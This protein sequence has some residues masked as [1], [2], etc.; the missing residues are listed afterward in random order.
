MLRKW[1]N[2]KQDGWTSSRN[3]NETSY[4]GSTHFLV[5]ENRKQK[6]EKEK[7]KEGW[8]NI[9]RTVS[10]IETIAIERIYSYDKNFLKGFTK[11]IRFLCPW[12]MRL[13]KEQDNLQ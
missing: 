5:K 2:L 8:H 1:T 3:A 7:R 4:C 12:R 6:T 11:Q 10:D 13:R 9:W